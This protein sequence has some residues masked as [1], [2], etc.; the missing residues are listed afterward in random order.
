MKK[1][2]EDNITVKRPGTGISPMKWYEI[3]G[4][5]AEKDYKLDEMI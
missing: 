5:Q 2:T 4:T 3:L 1:L